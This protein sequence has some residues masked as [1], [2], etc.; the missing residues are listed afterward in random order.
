ML[1]LFRRVMLG[2]G[3]ALVVSLAVVSAQ[4]TDPMVGT[5]KLNVA[6]STYEPGPAPKS[7]TR[8]IV[9]MGGGVFV[10]SSKGINDKGE[11]TWN[12]FAFR[13]DGKD[14]PYASSTTPGTSPSFVTVAFKRIDANT[15]EATSKVDGKV[16]ATTMT[17]TISKDGKTY[18]TRTKGTNAQGQPVNN[19]IVYEK[20]Q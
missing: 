12:H 9:D 11:A 14:Y 17:T 2:V 4:G 18:T 19:V 13:F 5:W 1:P 6:A 10:S 15:F 8:T 7:S 3:L 16:G 20:Q